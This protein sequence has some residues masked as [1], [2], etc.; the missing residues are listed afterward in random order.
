MTD[1]HKISVGEDI[2]EAKDILD[3]LPHRYP[4]LLIDKV[5]KID[6][7]E[8]VV[9][10][11]KNTTFNEA[12][13]QGH[14]P[15]APLMPGVLIIE[16]LAQTGGILVY[17]KGYADKIAVLMNVKNAKFRSPVRPGDILIL[18]VKGVHLGY[19]GGRFKVQAFSGDKLA[20]EAEMAF[21]LVNK[22]QL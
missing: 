13:F 5:L 9:I 6:L 15:G 14:F 16:A 20:V 4:F 3:I 17:K 12:F 1:S 2:I 22:N 11:Q 10:A 8:N 18:K 21:A 7:E 19:K